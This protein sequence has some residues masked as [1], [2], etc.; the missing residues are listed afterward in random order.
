MP[1]GTGLAFAE[2]LLLQFKYEVGV[3]AM[4]GNDHAEFL[5]EAHGVVEFFIADAERALVGE[6]NLEA[7]DACFNDV[8]ELAFRL[9]VE[10]RHGLMKRKIA[11]ALALGFAQPE[12]EAVGERLLRTRLT[13]HLDHGGRAADQ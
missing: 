5:G 8:G 13:D 4:R 1:F 2:K 11:G 6:K 9:L 12:L 7:A 10:A 3:F